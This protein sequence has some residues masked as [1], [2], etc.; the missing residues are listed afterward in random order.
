MINKV[1]IQITE[2][3]WTA[4]P[5]EKREKILMLMN[6]YGYDTKA[7][8]ALEEEVREQTIEDIY[9]QFYKDED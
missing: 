9:K 7:L 6:K 5:Q 2:E 3:E 1:K 4:M 8:H